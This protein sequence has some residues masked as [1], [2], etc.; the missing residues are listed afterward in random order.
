MQVDTDAHR[1]TRAPPRKKKRRRRHCLCR[2]KNV[3]NCFNPQRQPSKDSRSE[4]YQFR[5]HQTSQCKNNRVR[6]EHNKLRA[7]RGTS[8][9]RAG[10]QQEVAEATTCIRE[11]MWSAIQTQHFVLAQKTAELLQRPEHT[12]YGTFFDVLSNSIKEDV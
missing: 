5:S 12:P 4:K 7:G 3:E 1:C 6:V 9:R 10:A 2:P 11:T 8:W